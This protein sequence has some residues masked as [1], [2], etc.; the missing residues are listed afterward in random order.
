M[1]LQL[2][3]LNPDLSQ[4][5]IVKF[6]LNKDKKELKTMILK[7]ARHVERTLKDNKNIVLDL[8]KDFKMQLDLIN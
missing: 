3:L 2:R 5:K 6:L 4:K 1:Y 8:E 7:Y